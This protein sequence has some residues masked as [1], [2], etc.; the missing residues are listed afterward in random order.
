MIAKRKPSETFIAKK[1][2]N[3]A[4]RKYII[5]RGLLIERAHYCAIHAEGERTIREG[6]LTEGVRYAYL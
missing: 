3:E 6:A 1:N 2:Q 4:S 5:H